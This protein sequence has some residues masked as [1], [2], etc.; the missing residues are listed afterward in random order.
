M[1]LHTEPIMP[2]P[3]PLRSHVTPAAEALLVVSVVLVT[4]Q[5][6]NVMWWI[7]AFDRGHSQAERVAI[8]VAAL[9]A[10]LADLSSTRSAPLVFVLCGALGVACGVPAAIQGRRPLAVLGCFGVAAN[11]LFVLWY[12]FGLM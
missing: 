4:L 1:S 9:P 5:V 7:R 8:Y 2:T 3:S 11:G 10:F 12:L 6:A